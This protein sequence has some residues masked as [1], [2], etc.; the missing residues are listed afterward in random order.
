MLSARNPVDAVPAR[1]QNL[2][3]E[4]RDPP[5]LTRRP[6]A[7]ATAD[8]RAF[9]V[10]Y[11]DTEIEDFRPL[12][13][14]ERFLLARDPA[15]GD[16]LGVTGS[17][18]FD[19]TVPGGATVA[20]EGVAWVSVAAT[21]RRQGILRELMAQQHRD[22]AEAGL[23]VSV[24]TASEGGSTGGSDT[25]RP[26][27]RARYGSTGGWHGYGRTRRTRVAS[28]MS[29]RTPAGRSPRTCTGAGR[30]SP[31]ARCPEATAGGTTPCW[32]APNAGTA[33]P[34]C[35]TWR[36]RTATRPTG[37]T[38]PTAAAGWWTSS[39]PPRTRTPRCGEPCSGSTSLTR[40]GRLFLGSHRANAMA[41]AGLLA[42]GPA[43][44]ARLELAF[45][46]DREVCHGTHF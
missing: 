45:T 33:A 36:T 34:A 42:A 5:C 18:P 26:G 7:L 35:S 23:A 1:R 37:S 11:T 44:L 10:S 20:A 15:D 9:G 2:D 41:R 3:R 25:G 32:T 17:F 19:V 46:A 38:G 8:A 6:G 43:A 39:R 40:G 29:T 31:P 28:G 4:V 27:V 22:F 13:D 24:L 21:H 14:P 30:R 12:F 16:V